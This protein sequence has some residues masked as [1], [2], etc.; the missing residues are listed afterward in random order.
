M[1]ANYNRIE[2]LDGLRGIA[3]LMVLLWH[4][5]GSLS[6][7]D[8]WVAEAVYALT[9]FGRTGVDLF[10]VLSGYLIIGILVRHRSSSNA[11]KVF[12]WRRFLRI[13]PPYTLLIFIYWLSY[14]LFGETTAFNTAGGA[15]VQLLFQVTFTWNW[16]MVINQDVG[17]G[18]GVTWSVAIEE[19]FYLLFPWIVFFVPSKKLWKIL[20]VIALVSIVGR[21]LVHLA[22]P[23]SPLAPYVL[24]PFRLDGVGL[25]GLVALGMQDAGVRDWLLRKRRQIALSSAA[26]LASLP[27]LV[28]LIRDSMAVHM[29][30]WGHTY[31][32]AGFCVLLIFIMQN[33]GSAKTTVFRSRTLQHLGWYSYS[34]YLFHPVFLSICF[35]VAGRGERVSSLL[36]AVLAITALIGSVAFSAGLFWLVERHLQ[37]LGRKFSYQ[38]T[39]VRGGN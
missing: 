35:I 8:S 26:F 10:F 2:E 18:F 15:L 13:Y 17:T 30:L 21:G 22:V 24:T 23:A 31:L 33:I 25:G 6:G 19:W 29:Y 37:A 28:G 34:I 11:A 32:A 36:D 1:Q 12:Y 9:I 27:V 39:G 14:F 20:L 7:R 38:D 5:T 3:V 16:L 4:F